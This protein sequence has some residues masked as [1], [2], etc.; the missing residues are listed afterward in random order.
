MEEGV[1]YIANKVQN[2]L[3]CVKSHPQQKFYV[4][5]IACGIARFSIAEIGP[6]FADAISMENVILPQEFEEE[7]RKT[8]L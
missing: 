2:F 7:I 6:L 8:T 1:D 4:T 3:A 5:K